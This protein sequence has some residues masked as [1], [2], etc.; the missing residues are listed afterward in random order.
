MREVTAYLCT[1][2]TVMTIEEKKARAQELITILRKS[3]SIRLDP[4][5]LGSRVSVVGPTGKILAW[6]TV[7]AD[8]TTALVAL[9]A[10][11]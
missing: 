3:G 5:P 1:E 9:L 4:H 7:D 11:G 2:D 6:Q 8:T 10:Q